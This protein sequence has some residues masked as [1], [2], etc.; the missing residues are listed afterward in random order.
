MKKHAFKDIESE[1]KTHCRTA[2]RSA[3]ERNLALAELS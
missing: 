3:G 2:S 1:K